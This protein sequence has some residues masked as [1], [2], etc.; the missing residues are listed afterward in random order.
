MRSLSRRFGCT[1]DTPYIRTYVPLR[2][3]AIQVH[4]YYLLRLN[5][6]ESLK[7]FTDIG[8]FFGLKTLLVI[9]M[10]RLYRDFSLTD[11][12]SGQI[13][14]FLN[15][16]PFITAFSPFKKNREERGNYSVL[17]CLSKD[18]QLVFFHRVNTET[19]E[20]SVTSV[21]FISFGSY[22]LARVGWQVSVDLLATPPTLTCQPTRKL[23]GLLY[24][25]NI[26]PVVRRDDALSVIDNAYDVWGA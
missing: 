16:T 18:Y 20:T 5:E 8:T 21:T 10:D 24:T 17:R 12:N 9:W 4:R 19:F 25:V 2:K 11:A 15:G 3:Y 23:E 1:I 6:H 22:G 13:S 14:G 7:L 26:G